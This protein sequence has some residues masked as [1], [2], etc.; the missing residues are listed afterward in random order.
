MS[1]DE[2]RAQLA[3]E[4]AHEY[5]HDEYERAKA[6]GRSSRLQDLDPHDMLLR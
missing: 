3:H 6:E 2:L 5:V 4:N 1:E